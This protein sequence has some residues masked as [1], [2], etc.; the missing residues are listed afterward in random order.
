[1]KIYGHA[2]FIEKRRQQISDAIQRATVQ[3][4]G[5]PEGKRYHRFIGLADADFIHPEDRSAA[6]IVVEIHL[7]TGRSD[8]TLRAYLL[9]L[10]AALEDYAGVA[11]NDL[12]VILLETPPARWSIRGVVGDELKLPY[13]VNR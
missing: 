13:E 7:M 11:P 6:Y 2:G 9:A 5:L 10:Q 4:L 12:E 1:M 3:E 8:K